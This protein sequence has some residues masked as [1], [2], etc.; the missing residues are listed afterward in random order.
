MTSCPSASPRSAWSAALLVRHVRSSSTGGNFESGEDAGQGQGQAV[1][2]H[3]WPH[4]DFAYLAVCSSHG[5]RGRA[6]S[7]IGC[8]ASEDAQNLWGGFVWSAKGLKE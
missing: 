3:I 6:S 2:L 4:V 1:M 7:S 5:K 8:D